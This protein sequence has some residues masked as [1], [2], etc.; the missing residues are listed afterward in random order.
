MVPGL[1]TEA[2]Q[3]E[4][5]LCD[6]HVD[7]IGIARELMYCSGWPVYAARTLGAAHFLNLFPP[8]FAYRLKRRM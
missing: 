3:A 4:Q 2:R 8:H 5:I 6:R 1:I 7:R